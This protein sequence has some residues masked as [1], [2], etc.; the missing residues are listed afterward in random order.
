MQGWLLPKRR[1]QRGTWLCLTHGHFQCHKFQFPIFPALFPPVLHPSSPPPSRRSH[2]GNL[3]ILFLSVFLFPSLHLS[4]THIGYYPIVRLPRTSAAQN[5]IFT[6]THLWWDPNERSLI[7]CS[8]K[9][10]SCVCRSQR[11]HLPS[12]RSSAGEILLLTA[13]IPE[14]CRWLESALPELLIVCTGVRGPRQASKRCLLFVSLRFYIVDTPSRCDD[15]REGK[16]F[17]FRSHRKDLNF[18]E[19]LLMLNQWW[20]LTAFLQKRMGLLFIIKW[21]NTWK[22]LESFKIQMMLDNFTN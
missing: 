4:K 7:F 5:A 22:S 1:E 17:S 3:S 16:L 11:C 14:W 10:W 8:K 19:F 6:Q 18:I 21:I 20:I 15:V 2:H 12:P 13:N 9:K